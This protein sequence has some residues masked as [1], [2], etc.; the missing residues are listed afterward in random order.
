MVTKSP[1]LR[2]MVCILTI[3]WFAIS[4]S[5]ASKREAGSFA[6]ISLGETADQLQTA[7]GVPTIRGFNEHA[8]FWSYRFDGAN[9]WRVAIIQEGQVA[10]VYIRQAFGRTSHL[11]DG[12]G[13]R[14]GDSIAHLFKE[15][16]KTDPLVYSTYSYPGSSG[17]YWLYEIVGGKVTGIGFTRSYDYPLPPL[18]TDDY[19]D[20][21]TTYRALILV[22]ADG[23]AT[24]AERRFFRSQTCDYEGK[25]RM[26]ATKKFTVAGRRYERVLAQCSNTHFRHN[27]YFDTSAL[28]S[29]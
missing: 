26:V 14:L 21:Q 10:G 4:P 20:G 12:Q 7:L 18:S 5:V 16:G 9:T 28:A 27:F 23:D 29:R 13:I 6:G 8:R 19:R 22:K 3:S 1:A 11:G 15:R 25:W 24:G 17:T 2:V